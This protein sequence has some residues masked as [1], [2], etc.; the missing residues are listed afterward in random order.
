L[1][2][3]DKGQAK[4]TDIRDENW[5]LTSLRCRKTRRNAVTVKFFGTA[6]LALVGFV[7]TISFG[8]QPYVSP[9]VTTVPVPAPAAP[10]GGYGY[11]YAYSSTEQ[12]GVL[13]GYS[14]VLRGMGAYEKYHA[15][16]LTQW[17]QARAL[18]LQNARNEFNSRVEMINFRKQRAAN[19]T[20]EIAD[21]N[22]QLQSQRPVVHITQRVIE[23]N[24]Q[25]TWPAELLAVEFQPYRE[26][27]ESEFQQL[28]LGHADSTPAIKTTLDRMVE[29]ATV[30][31]RAGRME[32]SQL[33][34]AINFRDKA[35]STARKWSNALTGTQPVVVATTR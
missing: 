33:T 10:Y 8:Q 25:I 32:A 20:K 13:N 34:A 19:E 1:Y 35:G 7:P 11:P 6:L 21:H 24:G 5:L 30:N 29:F 3:S 26:V 2:Q 12:E 31:V 15:E 14:N 22:L 28:A 27:L 16:A 9:S 4:A 23:P 18:D 17:E